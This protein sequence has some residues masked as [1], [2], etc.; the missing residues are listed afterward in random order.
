MEDR[1]QHKA[2]GQGFAPRLVEHHGD[3]HHGKRCQSN[4]AA[5]QPQ[6]LVTHAPEVFRLKLKPDQ[7]QH[8]DHAEFREMLDRDDIDTQERKNGADDDT[9]DQ[10]AKDRAKAKPR[11]NGNRDHSWP[12]RKMKAS[13]RKPVM[14]HLVRG[15][16]RLGKGVPAV[17]CWVTFRFPSDGAFDIVPRSQVPLAPVSFGGRP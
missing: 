3:G 16:R 7:K 2:D 11:G 12:I 5:A 8:H 15:L 9:R 4:L 17:P 1:G 6:K 10:V 13:I 14:L